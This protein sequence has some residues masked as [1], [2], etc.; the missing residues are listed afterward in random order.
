MCFY[1]TSIKPDNNVPTV[2]LII[3]KCQ[4]IYLALENTC[5]ES[6]KTPVRRQICAFIYTLMHT[7][8]VTSSEQEDP[9][10]LGD[11]SIIPFE[12]N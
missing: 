8:A 12:E 10:G 11:L 1:Y 5:M 9:S 6:K 3:S 2:S 7:H 4:N